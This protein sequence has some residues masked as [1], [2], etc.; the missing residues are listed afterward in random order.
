[1]GQRSVRTPRETELAD[2]A[3]PFST[4]TVCKQDLS[5]RHKC[6]ATRDQ[7]LRKLSGSKVNC[8]LRPA[9]K[10]SRK[11]NLAHV[12]LCGNSPTPA[13]WVWLDAIASDVV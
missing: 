12:W 1:M 5:I 2:Q 6:Q 11:G 8:G 9:G 7:S 10:I 4:T 3:K 13:Y